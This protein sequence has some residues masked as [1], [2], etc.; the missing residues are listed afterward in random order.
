MV[1]NWSSAMI[2]SLHILFSDLEGDGW[3]DEPKCIFTNTWVPYYGYFLKGLCVLIC[4]NKQI[5]DI[6]WPIE[7]Y[8]IKIWVW[9]RAQTIPGDMAALICLEALYIW[10]TN[11]IRLINHS[12]SPRTDAPNHDDMNTPTKKMNVIEVTNPRPV[13]EIWASKNFYKI[14]YIYT[15]KFCLKLVLINIVKPV[16]VCFQIHYKTAQCVKLD[17]HLT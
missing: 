14:Q 16:E 4:N 15:K 6:N 11:G 1:F 7:T 17:S 13:E 9:T 3:S 2:I 10:R 12:P 8:Y 5:Q